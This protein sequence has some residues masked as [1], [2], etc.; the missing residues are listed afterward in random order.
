MKQECIPVGCEPSACNCIGLPDRDPSGQRPLDGEPLDRKP[1]D[2]DTIDSD[3][4][5]RDPL[6]RDPSGQSPPWTETPQTETP[7]DRDPG[8]TP[9]TETPPVDRQTPVK[10]LPS[11]TS[12]AGGNDQ[13]CSA[14]VIQENMVPKLVLPMH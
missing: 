3:P 1:S 2:R 6:D 10:T 14:F 5:V 13:G 4:L 11:Q 8:E 9:W 7:R 12:F